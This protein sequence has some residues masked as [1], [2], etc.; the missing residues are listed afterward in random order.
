MMFDPKLL[1]HGAV[2]AVAFGFSVVGWASGSEHVCDA[3]HDDDTVRVAAQKRGRFEVLEDVSL[4]QSV[5]QKLNTVAEK[6][7]RK[8]GKTFTVTSGTRDPVTQAEL[9]YAKLS[10]GDDIMKLYKDKAAISELVQ[11]YTTG[12]SAKKSRSAIVN[13]IASAIRAQVKKGVFISAHLKAGAAD[14]RSTTMSSAE[15]RAFV[16]AVNEAGGFEVMFE[17]TPP[18]F[19]LQVD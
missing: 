5:T 10:A 15:K 6:Y 8:T 16:D 12:Q 17:S 9:I 3:S 11:L 4:S 18:H 13:S 1:V 14:V 7:A 19:H 2:A